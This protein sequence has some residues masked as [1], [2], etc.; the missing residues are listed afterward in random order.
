MKSKK[1]RGSVRF[2]DRIYPEDCRTA[3]ATIFVFGDNMI[4]RGKAGQACIR[5]EPNAIGVPT[6]WNPSMV[7]DAFFSDHPVTIKAVEKIRQQ[8]AVIESF[9]AT[10]TDVSFPQDGLGTGLAEL[11]K[12]APNL[13][14]FIEKSI[15]ELK[16]LYP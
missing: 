1:A 3:V 13:Y 12:R 10:G 2:H 9:L 7:D 15:E 5:D 16:R 6:K 14:A 11:P 8:F 4:G